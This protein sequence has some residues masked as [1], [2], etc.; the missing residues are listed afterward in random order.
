MS[1]LPER[2]IEF[3]EEIVNMLLKVINVNTFSGLDGRT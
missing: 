2:N 3:K 1:L